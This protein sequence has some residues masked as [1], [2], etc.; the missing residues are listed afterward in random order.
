MGT[1]TAENAENAEAKPGFDRLFLCVLRV[2]RGEML[3]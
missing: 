2:L 1:C 3:F